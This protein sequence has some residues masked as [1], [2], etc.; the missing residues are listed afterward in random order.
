M[1]RL[2]RAILNDIIPLLAFTI[3]LLHGSLFGQA[4]LRFGI[5]YQCLGQDKTNLDQAGFDGL[6]STT[7][8]DTPFW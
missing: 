8:E 7:M 3:I 4:I 6:D 5:W 2:P 1:H